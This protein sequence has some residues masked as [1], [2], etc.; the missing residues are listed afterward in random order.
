MEL[1]NREEIVPWRKESQE[2]W[3]WGKPGAEIPSASD[4]WGE[5]GFGKLGVAAEA[6]AL[7]DRDLSDQKYFVMQVPK[8]LMSNHLY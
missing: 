7:C 5:E 3:E 8:R 4:T 6:Q 1:V 2:L